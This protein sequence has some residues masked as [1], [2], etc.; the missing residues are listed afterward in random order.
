MQLDGG[1]PLRFGQPIQVRAQL[2][3]DFRS[4]VWVR[5]SR[6]GFSGLIRLPNHEVFAQSGHEVAGSGQCHCADDRWVDDCEKPA[7][8][9]SG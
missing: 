9:L 8:V 6:F 3:H 2:G 7:S 4:Q 5:F 1:A